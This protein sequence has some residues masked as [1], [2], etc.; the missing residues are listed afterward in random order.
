[1]P[2]SFKKYIVVLVIEVT[3]CQVPLLMVHYIIA[4]LRSSR[5]CSYY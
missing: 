2:L 3:T 4:V 5:C 1:M